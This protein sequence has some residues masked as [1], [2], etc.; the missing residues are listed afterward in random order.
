MVSAITNDIGVAVECSYNQSQSKPDMDYFLFSYKIKITN[1]SLFDVQLLYRF[2]V[3]K[4][5]CNEKHILEGEGVVGFQPVIEAGQS[6]Q[7]ESYCQLKS[8][9]GSM[10][11]YYTFRKISDNSLLEAII[12]EFVLMPQYKQ[13]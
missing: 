13:N 4:D 9:G 8:D 1:H 11:G 10:H 7:Y 2:W 3:I 5:S 6:Y 12:P